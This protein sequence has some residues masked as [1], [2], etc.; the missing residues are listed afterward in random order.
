M[1]ETEVERGEYKRVFLLIDPYL[2]ENF[3]FLS[4]SPVRSS[5]IRNWRFPS[6][7]QV[8]AVLHHGADAAL[9]IFYG[10]FKQEPWKDLLPGRS[11][12]FCDAWMSSSRGWIVSRVFV[13]SRTRK[14]GTDLLRCEKFRR[15]KEKFP[16]RNIERLISLVNVRVWIFA[17]LEINS[18]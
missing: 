1:K 14:E 8:Y 10:L 15:L 6:Q 3:G 5:L 2:W 17:V 4:E 12:C 13:A 9:V 11:I 16:I 7:F 18:T